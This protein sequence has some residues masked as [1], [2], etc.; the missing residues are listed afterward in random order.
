MSGTDKRSCIV[1]DV[2]MLNAQGIRWDR[3]RFMEDFDVTLS[4]L[5]R[6]FPNTVQFG[7]CVGQ[8]ASNAPG[9]VS[10]ARTPESVKLEAETLRHYHPEYVKVMQKQAKNWQGMDTRYDV[11]VS[12][13]K[14][15]QHT[16]L[17]GVPQTAEQWW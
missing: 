1:M 8:G 12:W 2:E 15:L 9:G 16:D 10:D 3:M 5:R 6:G 7:W 11:S 17:R 4:L 13:K 14:A